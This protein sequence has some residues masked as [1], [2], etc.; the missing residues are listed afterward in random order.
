MITFRTARIAVAAISALVLVACGPSASMTAPDNARYD[1]GHT[2]GG[3]NKSDS[4]MTTTAP[5]GGAV[6]NSGGHTFGGGN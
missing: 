5:G 3:G 1:G 6:G 2:F 4:I